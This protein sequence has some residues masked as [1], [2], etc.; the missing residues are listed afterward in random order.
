MNFRCGSIVWTTGVPPSTPT[1]ATTTTVAPG[2]CCYPG[3]KCQLVQ[4][5]YCLTGLGGVWQGPGTVCGGTIC[6]SFTTTSTTTEAPG[7]C[8]YNNGGASLVCGYGYRSWCN[9]LN[10]TF[11]PGVGCTGGN[12]FCSPT[13]TTGAPLKACCNALGECLL[14]VESDG[15]CMPGTWGLG[16]FCSSG[17]CLGRCCLTCTNGNKVCVDNLSRG[18]CQA[19]AADGALCEG[20]PGSYEWA[21][22][23]VTNPVFCSNPL[24]PCTTTTTTTTGTPPSTPPPA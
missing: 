6:N 13:T 12:T 8:C 4:Q 3:G 11:T 18:Q 20:V 16:N 24:N 5:R 9:S 21:V 15:N 22:Y 7:A 17:A 14:T 19:Y 1:T 23:T 10:G 2:A